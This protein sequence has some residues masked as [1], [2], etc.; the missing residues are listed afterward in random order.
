MNR[1]NPIQVKFHA[2]LRERHTSISVFFSVLPHAKGRIVVS[3]K[4]INPKYLYTSNQTHK[5]TSLKNFDVKVSRPTQCFAT[6]SGYFIYDIYKCRPNTE[7]NPP[8]R[9][10]QTEKEEIYS[11]HNNPVHFM[12]KSAYFATAG[13]KGPIQAS[14]I[15]R[16]PIV[17]LI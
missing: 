6:I 9:R 3:A 4:V 2:R 10:K 11:F 7:A 13:G 16:T 5:T 8:K 14:N 17:V 12:I 1:R 15:S